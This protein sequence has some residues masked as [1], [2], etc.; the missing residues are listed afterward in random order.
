MICPGM[1]HIPTTIL[2]LNKYQMLQFTTQGNIIENR[3]S[4]AQLRSC[5]ITSFSVG[6]RGWWGDLQRLRLNPD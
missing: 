1:S 6:Y 5:L 3:L 4:S 2:K